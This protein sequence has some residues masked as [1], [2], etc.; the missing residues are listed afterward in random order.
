MSSVRDRIR[1]LQQSGH[2]PD[3]PAS[4]SS[5][6]VAKIAKS[7]ESTPAPES[8]PATS[9]L[10]IGA[11]VRRFNAPTSSPD[12]Q[13][14]STAS[15][16]GIP[17]SK[18]LQPNAAASSL[19]NASSQSHALTQTVR[20]TPSDNEDGR[21]VAQ[22]RLDDSHSKSAAETHVLNARRIFESEQKPSQNGTSALAKP[23]GNTK[24]NTTEII[25]T[26]FNRPS[27]FENAG[28]YG[29]PS[30]PGGVSSPTGD[31]SKEQKEALS[32]R[33]AIF[34]KGNSR[35]GETTLIAQDEEQTLSR[36]SKLREELAEV[37]ALNEKL[38]KS[39]LDLTEQYCRLEK[40]RDDLQNRINKLEGKS[41]K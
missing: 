7:L 31:L 23:H 2:K 9:T 1:D 27:A 40:S 11:R 19:S 30:G 26:V 3:A 10:G 35:G 22:G 6:S 8:A 29:V 14:S 32:T 15:A 24:K 36:S 28:T 18:S 12:P 13:N 4:T 39:L 20:R 37:R 25:T 16:R 33:S 34:E 38:A 21:V 17:V 41:T 5:S